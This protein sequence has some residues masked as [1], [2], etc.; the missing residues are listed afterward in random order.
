MS[1]T[2]IFTDGRYTKKGHEN[3]K[4][5]IGVFLGEKDPRNVS[6]RLFD[7]ILTNNRAE[8]MAIERG[9]DLAANI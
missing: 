7:T 9:I 1:K 2:Y 3:I 6:E 5:G 4:A 8:F